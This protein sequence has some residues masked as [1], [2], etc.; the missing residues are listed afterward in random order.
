MSATRPV[1]SNTNLPRAMAW[2]SAAVDDSA[3]EQTAEVYQGLI[4]HIEYSSD[5]ELAYQVAATSAA[6][7]GVGYFR[8]LT[9]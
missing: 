1:R 9:D 6:S 8:L 4:R 7:C 3:D 5:A 2:M